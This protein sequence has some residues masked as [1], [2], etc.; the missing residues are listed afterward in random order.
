MTPAQSALRYIAEHEK[1]EGR[2]PDSIPFTEKEW[3]DVESEAFIK[4][5]VANP[6]NEFAGILVRFDASATALRESYLW[7]EP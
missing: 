4:Y 6:R 2:K 1:R 7:I 5:L 3:R